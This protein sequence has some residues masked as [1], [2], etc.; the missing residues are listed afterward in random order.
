MAGTGDRAGVVL[1]ARDTRRA[2]PWSGCRL[3]SADAA[4][5]PKRSF[6]QVLITPAP[7]WFVEGHLSDESKAEAGGGASRNHQAEIVG[8]F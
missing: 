1:R 4:L 3:C 2:V 7:A 6:L 5:L 8:E